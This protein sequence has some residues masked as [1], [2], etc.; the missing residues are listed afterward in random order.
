[1]A[2]TTAERVASLLLAF[3]DPN[4]ATKS[5]SELAAAV[6]RERSQV[7]RMLKSLAR[8]GLLEQDESTR[9][10]RL[11]WH[12]RILAARAGDDHLVRVCRPI[13]QQLVAATGEV[14]LL[15]VQEGNRSLT[16]LREESRQSLQAGGWVGRRSPLHYTASGRALMFDSDDEHIESLVSR[17]LGDDNVG[18]AAPRDVQTVLERTEADRRRGYSVASEEIEV[19]LT[20]TAAPIRDGLGQIVGVINVSG[21]SARILDRINTVGPL[22]TRAASAV[23]AK[24]G[25]KS[26]RQRHA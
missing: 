8:G 4:S 15:S 11:G 25:A 5:V 20:S 18:P 2:D 19:G 9:Q 17:D 7:S 10:Y 14:S 23:S 3:E 22:V 13:L 16:V 1:M 21:P 12:L 26:T 24:M 6:G